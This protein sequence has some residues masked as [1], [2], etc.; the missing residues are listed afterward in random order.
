MLFAGT[1]R[2]DPGDGLLDLLL[3]SG[4]QS[5]YPLARFP[6]QEI[7]IFMFSRILTIATIAGLAGCAVNSAG[8]DETV[9]PPAELPP[10]EETVAVVEVPLPV[11]DPV[12]GECEVLLQSLEAIRPLL[13]NL[14]ESLLAQAD[15]IDAAVAEL[16]R[17]VPETPALV[18]PP[19]M[20]GALGGKEIIG[21]LEWLYM[22]PPGRHFRAR[23]DSG[24]D[25]SSLSASDV[26]EFER[27]GDDWVRFTFEHDSAEESVEFELPIKRTV[28]IRQVSSDTPDRRF[29]IELD[30]RLG[31]QLQ[32][33][34]FTLTNRSRMTYPILLG[35][36]FLMDLY[37][38]DVSRSYTHDRYD[39]AD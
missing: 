5:V 23:V 30:I 14:D 4:G 37:V 33:T 18:C 22:D 15:R 7:Y 11:E 38:V 20:N 19:N 39:D 28:L 16:N 6:I 32:T 13:D 21:A 24:A 34:E 26:V 12:P 36:A 35:R 25:T 9:P 29:V 31:D 3:L 8:S 27:D 10:A 17:P 2:Q 1:R